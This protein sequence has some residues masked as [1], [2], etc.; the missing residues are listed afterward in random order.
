MHFWSPKQCHDFQENAHDHRWVFGSYLV[1]GAYRSQTLNAVSSELVGEES[2][3]PF[4]HFQ[5]SSANSTKGGSQYC[6]SCVNENVVLK[7]VED[8]VYQQ[9]RSS[10]SKQIPHHVINTG[11]ANLNPKAIFQRKLRFSCS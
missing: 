5:Y 4:K 3:R 2:P 9:V 11:A 8:V 1:L 6:L 10:L 7:V